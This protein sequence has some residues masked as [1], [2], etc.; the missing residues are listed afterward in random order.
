[1][2][3]LLFGIIIFCLCISVKS[4]A[5]PTYAGGVYE[6]AEMSM[7][8]LLNATD[9]ILKETISYNARGLESVEYY[10]TSFLLEQPELNDVPSQQHLRVYKALLDKQM[11]YPIPFVGAYIAKSKFFAESPDWTA[12][13]GLH[14]SRDFSKEQMALARQRAQVVLEILEAEKK[15]K[16]AKKCENLMKDNVE[17]IKNNRLLP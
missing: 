16:D 14:W 3:A 10:F 4:T 17:G 1:M 8:A 13:R 6:G 9:E 11:Y 7:E 12:F 2:K 5:M 15:L